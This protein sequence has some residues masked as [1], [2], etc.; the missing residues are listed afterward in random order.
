[1]SKRKFLTLEERVDVIKKLNK[2]LSVRKVADE[3]N[4]EKTQISNIKADR[5]QILSQWE[6][7]ARSTGKCV[8]RRKTTYDGLNDE[9]FEWFSRARSKN[10]PVNGPLL[11]ERALVRSMELGFDDFTASNGWLQ[12]WQRRY[13]VNF[14]MRSGEA[15][16]VPLEAVDDWIKRLPEITKDYAL[17]DIFN[18]DETGLYF[19]A[20][21]Q[22]SMIVKGDSRKGIRTAKDRITVL[23]ACSGTGEKLTPL[24]IGRA[25][26][27]RCFKAL[28]KSSLPVTYR[29]NRKAWMTAVLF[30]EWL[31]KLNTK[32][33]SK[34]R[35][36]LLMVDNCSAHC[37]VQLSNIKLKFLP[38]NTTSKLQPCDAGV[39]SIFKSH[40]RKRLLRHILSAMDE[41]NT[42]SELAKSVSLLHAIKW[43]DLAWTSVR[44]SSIKKCFSTADLLNPLL[45]LTQ[46]KSKIMETSFR[47][48]WKMPLGMTLSTWT[49]TCP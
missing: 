19:R 23:L 40:Y 18:A 39:I 9:L 31:E 37:H 12:S 33:K 5:S 35:N 27:P 7:G 8:K 15:S 11:Q 13:N 29:W 14:A 36:I 43:L 41:A 10:I 32:M 16:G 3:L 4:C 34:G 49:R 46:R 48:C 6:S 2:G 42:A 26:N 38:P 30:K 22:R 45:T 47:P 28:K 21:P 44:G 24:V 25:E 20:L 1:M 17:E